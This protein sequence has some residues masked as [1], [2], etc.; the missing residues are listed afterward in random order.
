MLKLCDFGT[1][2]V[3]T[4]QKPRSMV[5]IGTLSYTAPEVYMR[6]A[7]YDIALH[8]IILYYFM[9][10]HIIYIAS[11]CIVLYYITL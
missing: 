6:K 11:Y 4:D 3:L 7:V 2:M 10:H 5:N 9:L 1:A 8:Y